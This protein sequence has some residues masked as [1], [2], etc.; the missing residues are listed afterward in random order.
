M[1]GS[2]ASRYTMSGV[3][4]LRGKVASL[5]SRNQGVVFALYYSRVNMPRNPGT[6]GLA[7]EVNNLAMVSQVRCTGVRVGEG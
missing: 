3:L 1:C 7:A 5:S 4:S 2:G 6:L